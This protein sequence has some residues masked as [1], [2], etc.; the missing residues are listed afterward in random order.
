MSAHKEQILSLRRLGGTPREI[1]KI[2]PM[3]INEIWQTIHDATVAG[4]IDPPM[5]T[6]HESAERASRRRKAAI[7]AKGAAGEC[8]YCGCAVYAP[9]H[10]LSQ[11]DKRRMA[12]DDH[13]V[14]Q[15]R[16]GKETVLSCF[17]CNN[18]KGDTP[19]EVYTA[20]MAT[21]PPFEQR[22][23]AYHEFRNALLLM[24]LPV[25]KADQREREINSRG[26]FT[27]ADLRRKRPA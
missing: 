13:I 8:H 11:S 23:A 24:G 2:V 17:L 21:N 26:R 10:P 3:P 19:Y 27:K 7:K 22:R 5:E 20:F 4:E 6:P 15:S 14:P 9:S 1:A 16:G 25:W 18:I 12:T